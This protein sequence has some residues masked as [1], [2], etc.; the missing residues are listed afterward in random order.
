M[1]QSLDVSVC[2]HILTPGFQ[3]GD[4]KQTRVT[5]F[6][7]CSFSNTCALFLFIRLLAGEEDSLLNTL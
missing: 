6:D 2:P 7:A 4:L 1:F 5:L 3:H